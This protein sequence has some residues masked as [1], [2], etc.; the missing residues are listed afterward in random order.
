MMTTV[1]RAIHSTNLLV[2]VG[3]LKPASTV[4]R[5]AVFQASFLV[6][7]I[8]QLLTLR[9]AADE[10]AECGDQVFMMWHKTL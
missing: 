9:D 8:V 1:C 7:D 5:L 2:T 3:T 10:V 6:V 4:P